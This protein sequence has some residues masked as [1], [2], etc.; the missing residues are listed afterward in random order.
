MPPA[1]AAAAAAAVVVA[2]AIAAAIAMTCVAAAAGCCDGCRA[3]AGVI[4]FVAE[5]LS[6]PSPSSTPSQQQHTAQVEA[7][8]DHVPS[9]SFKT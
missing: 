5:A 3:L 6:D 8:P 7:A 9:L 1:A 2:A 4:A